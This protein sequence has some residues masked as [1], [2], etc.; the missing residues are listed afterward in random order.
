M[1]SRKSQMKKKLEEN[2]NEATTKDLSL[3]LEKLEQCHETLLNIHL[4]DNETLIKHLSRITYI[5][6]DV[7]N[8][9]VP[10]K[11]KCPP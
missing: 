4:K 5:V 1:K 10:H 8:N 11:R 7:P 2:P 6:N 9:Q 3:I